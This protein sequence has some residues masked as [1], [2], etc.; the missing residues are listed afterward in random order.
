[1]APPRAAPLYWDRLDHCEAQAAILAAAAHTMQGYQAKTWIWTNSA[2]RANRQQKRKRLTSPLASPNKWRKS[3]TGAVS[4]PG[5]LLGTPVRLDCPFFLFLWSEAF[6]CGGN[7]LSW[8]GLLFS[9]FS[10]M[11]WAR[12]SALVSS[13]PRLKLNARDK[14]AMP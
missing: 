14:Q 10:G 4:P 7:G 2:Q 6:G 9:V 3:G 1:M 13:M 5:P 11:L 8:C 12:P